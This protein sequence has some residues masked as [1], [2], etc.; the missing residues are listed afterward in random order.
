M[1]GQTIASCHCGNRST[2]C[3]VEVCGVKQ[4]RP[5]AVATGVKDCGV[6]QLR[7]VAVAT[8]VLIVR[9]KFVGS[10]NRVLLLGQRVSRFV[11]SNICVLSLWQQEY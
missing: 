4:L 11:G 1:W 2:N 6:K 10:K 7:P 3:Q 5:V 9:L 8:G